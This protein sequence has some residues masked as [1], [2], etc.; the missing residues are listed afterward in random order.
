MM[1][2]NSKEQKLLRI[3]IGVSIIIPIAVAVL[4]YLPDKNQDF[5]GWV[6]QIPAFNAMVNSVTAFVLLIAFIAIKKKNV[7]L[8]KNMM[9]SAFVL[10]ALFLIAYI[11]YH[12]YVPSVKFG[13]TN[14]DFELDETEALA[15]GSLKYFYYFVLLSHIGLSMVVVPLVLFAFYFALTN[16]IDRHKKLV[17]YTFPIWFYVS[18]S[19]VLTYFMISPYY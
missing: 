17:K 2:G 1:Y 11:V 18:I 4:I 6:K 15:I 7:G 8:H 9:M 5:G 10:G 13:D 14:G 16:K 12:Y 3:I 19:G